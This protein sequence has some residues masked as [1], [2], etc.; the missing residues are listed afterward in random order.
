MKKHLQQ[1]LSQGNT[2]KVIQELLDYTSRISDDELHQEVMMQSARY[3]QYAKESR[4]GI[5]SHGEQQL[6]LNKINQSILSIIQ[7]LPQEESRKPIN[8]LSKAGFKKQKWWQWVVG[9]GVIIGILAGIAEFTGL[10]LKGLFSST[11]TASNTVTVLVHGKDGKADLVLPNR[12]IV[13]LIYGDAIVSKQINNEGEAT[14]RQISDAFFEDNVQVEVVFQDPKGEPY[15]AVDP[16]NKYQLTRGK[17][18]PLEVR[19]YGLDKIRGIV[20]NFETGTPIEGVRISIQGEA[21]F[22][23]QYGEYVLNIPEEKQQQFQTI[24]AL[25]EGYES[26]EQADVPTQTQREIPILLK[27]EK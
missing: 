4:L 21:A 25:K 24:R 19:L 10:N 7:H 6:T 3:E 13:K 9:A 5:T 2:K 22:S 23:N 12:G 15:R 1:L 17:Y 11:S 27:P 20:K 18:I 14:F 26:Y 8:N 16:D